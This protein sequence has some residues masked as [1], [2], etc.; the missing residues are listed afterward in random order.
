M[1]LYEIE[2][3]FVLGFFVHPDVFP[4]TPSRICSLRE[5]SRHAV[6]TSKWLRH[7]SRNGTFTFL[8]G[9]LESVAKKL[10]AVRKTNNKALACQTKLLYDV[11]VCLF[12]YLLNSEYQNL[13]SMQQSKKIVGV[14]TTEVTGVRWFRA[15]FVPLKVLTT[16]EI[17]MFVI[18]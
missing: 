8:W 3:V 2:T 6:H 13:H 14:R 16:I 9:W 18:L 7:V 5:L 11:C 17:Q 4:C 12:L 10:N 1:F 15:G